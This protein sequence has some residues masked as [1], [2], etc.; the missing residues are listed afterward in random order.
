MNSSSL[1]GGIGAALAN[2][3]FRLFWIGNAISTIGRWIYRTAIGWLVWELTRDPK[4]LGIVAFVDVFPMVVLSIVAGAIS[5]R[6]GFVKLIKIAQLGLCLM[7]TVFAVSIYVGYLSIELIIGVSIVHGVLEAMSTPPR[8][9]IVHS[10]VGRDDLSSAIALNSAMFNASRVLGPAIGGTLLLWADPGTVITL[11]TLAFIQFYFVMMFLKVAAEGGGGRISWELFADMKDGFVYCWRH[12]GIRFLMLMLTAVGLLIRPVMEF[13]P[14][15]A[16]QVFNRG[17]E[18]YA[19]LLSSIGGGALIASLWLARRGRTEGLTRLVVA[20]L[21]VQSMAVMA[22]AFSSDIYV[23]SAFLAGMGFFMLIG[24]VGSQTLI[25][26]AVDP[27]LRARAISLF[28]MISWGFP[29]IGALVAGW[30][31]SAA[32]LQPTIA[33]GA[34]LTVLIWLRAR[35]AG[36]RVAASLE[37]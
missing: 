26:N 1:F 19:M 24:G 10:L 31:A 12:T 14:G 33:V 13:A 5:D 32:G 2:P 4:W 28:I 34:A 35:P 36:R 3:Q 27:A 9:A 18:G 7:G 22:F 6:V 15:F 29:A 8:I 21:V 20:S 16:A 37:S 17:P 23:G 11:A 25:Q 30:I